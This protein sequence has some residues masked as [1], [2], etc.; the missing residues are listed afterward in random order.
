MMRLVGCVIILVAFSNFVAADDSTDKVREGMRL[1]SAEQFEEASKSFAAAT[2]SLEKTKS[3]KAAIAAYDEA[4]ALH[5][6]GDLELARERYL[7]A[8]LSHDKTIATN[9]HFNIGVIASEHARKL[10]GETPETV[11][12]DKRKEIL[13]E[14]SRS[15]DS[16]RH[17][18]ELQ[19]QYAPARRN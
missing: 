12:A 11:P 10:A 16:Y 14:L 7:K 19:P 8:G 17:C 9:A 4:C 1:Y 3:D 18:L 15:I 6:K 5:R 13:D 2:E